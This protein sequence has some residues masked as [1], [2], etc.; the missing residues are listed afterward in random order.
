MEINNRDTLQDRI[1]EAASK[2]KVTRGLLTA[3]Q[4]VVQARDAKDQAFNI[5]FN[6]RQR[7]PWMGSRTHSGDVALRSSF[8]KARNR[9]KILQKKDH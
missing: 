8:I 1:E 2:G 6:K 5:W 3:Y 4:S 9:R 7:R